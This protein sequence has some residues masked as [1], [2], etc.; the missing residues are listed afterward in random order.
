[1]SRKPTPQETFDAL[2]SQYETEIAAAML[3][4]FAN[5]RDSADAQAIIAA[6][7]RGDTA[8]ALAAL[9]LDPAAFASFNQTERNAFVTAGIAAIT[10]L[11][12]LRSAFGTLVVVRF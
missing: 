9:H 5:I 2:L 10:L 4:A 1:M 6:L 11:P 12:A 7:E 3:A 8:E